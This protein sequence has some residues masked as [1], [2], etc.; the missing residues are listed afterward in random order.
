MF[1]RINPRGLSVKLLILTI[2]FI[3]FAEVLIFIPSAAMFRQNWLWQRAESARLIAVAIEGVPNYEGSAMLSRQFMQSTG[4]S[5]VTQNR[6]GMSELVLGA[7]PK[8]R[9]VGVDDLRTSR[10]LPLFRKTFLDFF[11]SGDGYLRVLSNP[12][13]DGVHSLEFLVPQSELKSALLDY[14]SRVLLWSI[15]ISLM[16]GVLIYI[17]LSRLIVAPIKQLAGDLVTFRNDPRKRRQ[18]VHIPKRK[19]EIGQLEREFIEMKDGVRLALKRQE[20]LATLGM[21][22]AKINHDLRNVLTSAQLISDRLESDPDPRIARMGE[23]LVKTVGR[24]VKL[25]EATLSFSQS[26]ED[27]PKQKPV[28]IATLIGEVAGDT[29]AEEGH[30]QFTNKVPHNLRAYI[31]PDHTYRIFHNLF[32]NA[33]QAMA[34]SPKKE[35]RVSA[36]PIDDKINFI[37]SDTGPGLPQKARANLF[38]AFTSSTAKGGTGLGLTISRELARAQ[39]GDLALKSSADEGT[40]FVLRLPIVPVS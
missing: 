1:L 36:E 3:M 22:M 32:R 8:G 7:P 18:E 6:E 20:R 10:R 27:P 2:V 25:C 37:I 12:S 13:V 17:A 19:D 4:V 14:S 23:R 16:T 5:M 28:R 30:V 38:K 15:V 24:G 21:A 11:S 35:L 40:V 9:I 39:G 26:V 34:D 31:D 29:M 33:I